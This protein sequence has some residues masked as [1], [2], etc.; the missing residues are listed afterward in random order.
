MNNQPAYVQRIAETA[1]YES[2]RNSFITAVLGSRRV[3]KSTLIFHFMNHHPDYKWVVLNMDLLMLRQRVAIGKLN[4][5]IEEA[6]LQKIGEGKKIWVVI[7]EAQKC[8]ELFEQIKIIY[9]SWKDKNTIKFILTGSALLQLHQLSAETLAGRIYL[10]YLHAFGLQETAQLLHPAV[11]MPS[12]SFFDLLQTVDHDQITERIKQW[13]PFQ[14]ILLSALEEQLIW[15]GFP[16]V[17]LLKSS[18]AKQAYLSSYIQTYLEKD[19]R[20]IHH[21]SDIHLYQNLMQIIAQ[22]TGSLRDDTKVLSVLNCSR[23]TL[24]KYRDYLS[25]TLLLKDIYP[26]I[27]SPLKRLAKSPKTY[28][29]DNG[30]ISYLTSIDDLD[31]LQ[32]TGLIGHRLENWF[33]KELQIWL[34][35]GTKRYQIY[36]WRTSGQ[37]EVDFVVEKI[38]YVLPFEITYSNKIDTKKIRNLKL[39]LK[40]VPNASY[41]F[42]IYMGNYHYDSESRI[43]FLP[44]W[45]IG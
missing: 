45:L 43:H 26:Y 34:D 39:F 36:Y 38:P 1:I 37:V 3:G 41:G 42:Y 24:K 5:M 6:A 31:I 44:A 28:F 21:I 9:D 20:D 13:Q 25:A 30:L 33:L 15:G 35:C 22:Q 40:E 17:L 19:I 32:K 2:I 4:E 7:D 10:H 16:E 18:P 27:H 12:S 14:R 8:P 23:N 11:S 29:L